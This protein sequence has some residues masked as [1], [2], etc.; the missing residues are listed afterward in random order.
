VGSKCR[1]P[2]TCFQPVRAVHS[3]A[4]HCSSYWCH[5][6]PRLFTLPH[7]SL[8]HLWPVQRVSHAQ[9]HKQD[10]TIPQTTTR[11]FG[12]KSF[13]LQCKIV[14]IETQGPVLLMSFDGGSAQ[15]LALLREGCSIPD[16][17]VNC[18]PNLSLDALPVNDDSTHPT[19]VCYVAGS[20]PS[21][22][23]SPPPSFFPPLPPFTAASSTCS[24]SLPAVV[25]PPS[26]GLSHWQGPQGTGGVPAVAEAQRL[27]AGG[28]S[29][30]IFSAHV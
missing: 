14:K 13:S 20:H 4:Y 8:T 19:G 16:H 5:T 22:S 18:K 1:H 6:N 25:L 28:G 24:T 11:Y 3:S 15:A 26:A 12:T 27:Q 2:C 23:A 17:P 30:K 7:P 29:H 9:H 21:Q 10:A